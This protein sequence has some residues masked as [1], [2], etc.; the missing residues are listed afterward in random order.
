MLKFAYSSVIGNSHIIRNIKNQDAIKV[1]SSKEY[2]ISSIADGHGSDICFRSDLGSKFAVETA[3]EVIL[4]NLKK[5]KSLK[6]RKIVVNEIVKLWREKVKED[7][8]NNS[9]KKSEIIDINKE[10]MIKIKKNNFLAYGTTL[11]SVVIFDK[12]IYV[13]NIGDSELLLKF[14]D[15]SV[16][17]IN[18]IRRLGNETESLSL[19]NSEKYFN[20]H[21]FKKSK[22]KAFLMATDGYPNSF[23]TEKDFLKVIDD[24]IKIEKDH[25]MFILEKNLPYWLKDT[26]KY[27]SGDDI[28]LC[29]VLNDID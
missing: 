13:F 4:R 25:G 17:V 19:K 1:D 11:M 28:S 18:D 3:N 27:G 2:F 10:K 20:L 14:K 16:K 8:K 22:I 6:N 15:D 5:L 9:V 26:S 23:K 7:I 12:F 21:S 29:F 24:L